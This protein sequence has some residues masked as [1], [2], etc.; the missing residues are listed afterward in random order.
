MYM[1]LGYKKI[2]PYSF[3]EAVEKTRAALD[4]KGFGV[5]MAGDVKAA[6][7]KTLGVDFD[8][9]TILGACKPQY[10]IH[11]LTFDKE[12]GHL[13]PCNV[14]VYTDNGK[15]IVSAVLPTKRFE[16]IDAPEL[17]DMAK[18]VEKELKEVIDSL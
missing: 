15:T 7:K 17:K 3:S 4:A 14:L 12:I 1:V 2:V 9:Y 18:T 8:N 13:L 5:L 10:S 16:L 11:A 6:L